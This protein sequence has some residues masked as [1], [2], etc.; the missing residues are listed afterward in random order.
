VGPRM[1]FSLATEC[2]CETGHHVRGI[3]QGCQESIQPDGDDGALLKHWD[4]VN[5]LTD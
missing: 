2:V 3:V 5:T 1:S 4:M